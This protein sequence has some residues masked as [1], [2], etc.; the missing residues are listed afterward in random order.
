MNGNGQTSDAS[1]ILEK[2]AKGSLIINGLHIEG[3]HW[4]EET[5]RLVEA[6]PKIFVEP[7]PSILLEPTLNPEE[8][9]YESP[10]SYPCPVYRTQLR[11]GEILPTGHSTNYIFQM[12]LPSDVHPQHWIRRGVA[13]V[14]ELCPI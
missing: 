6:R 11:A 3:A 10:F 9:P 12:E 7:L 13:A 5:Q 8:K 2:A 4:D 14:L 1:G